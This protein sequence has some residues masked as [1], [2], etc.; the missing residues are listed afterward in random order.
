MPPA[1]FAE[2]VNPWRGSESL[3]DA[4][5]QALFAWAHTQMRA[6]LRGPYR[7]STVH[8]RAGRP[9]PRCGELI[10]VRAQGEQARLT[11]WCPRCQQ[12]PSPPGR[13]G[14]EDQYQ[15]TGSSPVAPSGRHRAS[16]RA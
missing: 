13:V 15:I 3:T 6:H 11:Y 1:L 4:Q 8:G 12:N 5:L 2:R 10:K 9:C 7:R 16:P 14:V